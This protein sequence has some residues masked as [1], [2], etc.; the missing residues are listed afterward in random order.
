MASGRRRF[1]RAKSQRSN[2]R[3]WFRDHLVGDGLPR[4]VSS[5]ARGYL[6][7]RTSQSHRLCPHRRVV[8]D[9]RVNITLR[10]HNPIANPIE[11]VAA[12]LTLT[13]CAN[14]TSNSTCAAYASEPM[15]F[16]YEGDLDLNPIV[17]PAS[18][19]VTTSPYAATALAGFSQVRRMHGSL[20]CSKRYSS[21]SMSSAFRC[22]P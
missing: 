18:A 4:L 21:S 22:W 3:M 11:L 16:F 7:L 13:L 2:T 10:V 9:K 12:N 15:G 1:R 14:Q 19:T 5:F 8:F 6:G 20:G 17:V